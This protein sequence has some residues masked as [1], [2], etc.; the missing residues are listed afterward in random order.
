[1]KHDPVYREYD[2]DWVLPRLAVAVIVGCLAALLFGGCIPI[3]KPPVVTPLPLR[4]VAVVVTSQGEPVAGAAVI[5]DS[6]PSPFIGTTDAAG[7]TLFVGVPAS[8]T[9]S[10]LWVTARGFDV[11]AAHVDVP[12]GPAT[13]TVTLTAAKP[14]P[15]PVGILAVRANFCALED[16]ATGD[17]IFTSTWPS[18]DDATRARWLQLARDA[19]D[20]HYAISIVQGYGAIDPDHASYYPDR[21]P[22]FVARLRELLAAGLVPVVYLHSGD[23]YPGTPY[24]AG[25]LAQIPRDLYPRILWV[26]GW[27]VVPG[28]WT[29]AELCK[30]TRAIR[31]ALG[32]DAL[33]GPFM[34][35]HLG[36]GRL[37]F[38]SHPLEDDDPFKGDE[39]ASVRSWY[40]QQYSA[41]LYQ[42]ALIRTDDPLSDAV[43]GSVWERAHEVLTRIKGDKWQGGP[44]WFAGLPVRWRAIFWEQNEEWYYR[45][46]ETRARML[47]I[48]A[49]AQRM[50]WQGYGAGQPVR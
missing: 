28:G 3:A 35:L 13:L 36:D 40:G 33:A 27:E 25:V 16:P 42:S 4:A 5:L 12:A 23:A 7:R 34:A 20:T 18:R 30:A 17:A 11:Y 26:P 45:D 19:G 6:V 9:D 39:V 43:P 50:G 41:L 29:T 37:S 15:A 46:L 1:M 44:D 49:A 8:L 2:I 47:D 22:L 24:F 32:G 14:P 38:S 31:E 21:M 48:S 10:H